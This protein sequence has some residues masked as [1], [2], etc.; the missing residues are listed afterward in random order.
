MLSTVHTN[1]QC[2]PLKCGSPICKTFWIEKSSRTIKS[3]I[4]MSDKVW[5]NLPQE[6]GA[7][8]KDV[9]ANW[10]ESASPFTF[11]PT[12]SL[13]IFLNLL[14]QGSQ[15]PH[16][17]WGVSQSFFSTKASLALHRLPF[18]TATPLWAVI[19]SLELLCISTS[20]ILDTLNSYSKDFKGNCSIVLFP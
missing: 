8:L 18:F 5:C 16:Y 12:E 19:R 9:S 1:L 14:S 11:N 7:I 13:G 3:T 17:L 6:C 15:L 2:F 20:L 4:T 10:P